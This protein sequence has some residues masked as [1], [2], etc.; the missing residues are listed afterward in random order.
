MLKEIIVGEKPLLMMSNGATPIRYKMT[1]KNDLMVELN[2]M[3]NGKKDEAEVIDLVGRLA[4]VMATQATGDRT[5]IAALSFDNYINWLEGF[6]SMDFLKASKEIINLYLG[7]TEG[8]SK[9]K[10]EGGRQSEK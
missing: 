5:Q 8:T 6:G 10:K 4:Y 3:S 2:Q 7:Q 1:F 9:P